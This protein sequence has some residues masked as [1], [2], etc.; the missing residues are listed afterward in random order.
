MISYA[1]PTTPS[2]YATGL[3][4]P[5]QPVPPVTPRDADPNFWLTGRQPPRA[6]DHT[7]EPK[8]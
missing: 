1:I 8:H 6:P 5:V 4:V 2:G 7:A 3:N